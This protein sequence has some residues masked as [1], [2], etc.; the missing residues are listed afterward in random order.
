[1]I[2]TTRRA[3]KHKHLDPCWASEGVGPTSMHEQRASGSQ[4]L[5]TIRA[6]LLDLFCM[7]AKHEVGFK[8]PTQSDILDLLSKQ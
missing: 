2:H 4:N 8:L 6:L 3:H 7:R 1:M 5:H